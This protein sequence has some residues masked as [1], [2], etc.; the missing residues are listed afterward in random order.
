MKIRQ[1][2]HL[3]NKKCLHQLCTSP[4]LNQYKEMTT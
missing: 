2:Q 1:P 4:D 3:F